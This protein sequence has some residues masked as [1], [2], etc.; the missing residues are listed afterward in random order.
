MTYLETPTMNEQIQ[1]AAPSWDVAHIFGSSLVVVY[2]A[3][4][5]LAPLARF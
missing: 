1:T 3:L 4:A 5:L 2:A